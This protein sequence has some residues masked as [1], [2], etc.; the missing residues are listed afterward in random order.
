MRREALDPALAARIR[1]TRW[2]QVSRLTS[3]GAEVT[4]R[5]AAEAGLPALPGEWNGA[6]VTTCD[7]EV[8][9]CA[10]RGAGGAPTAEAI[11]GDLRRLKDAA[12]C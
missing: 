1:G 6:R 11:M 3:D 9:Q 2:V 4:L 8:F 7:G 12:R 5:P 10:G